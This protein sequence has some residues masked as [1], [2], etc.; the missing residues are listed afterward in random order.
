MMNQ[1]AKQKRL[2]PLGKNQ[3]AMIELLEKHGSWSPAS[4][5]MWSHPS[6]TKTILDSLVRYGLVVK[7]F[8]VYKLVK[9]KS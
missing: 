4:G 8:G 7:H 5:W 3:V 2:R 6:R 9:V 1:T